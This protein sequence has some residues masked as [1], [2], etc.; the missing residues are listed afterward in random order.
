MALN[1]AKDPNTVNPMTFTI[2]SPPQLFC[3]SL[4]YFRFFP[5]LMISR[6]LLYINSLLNL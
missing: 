6:C 3:Q 5:K 4:L 2:F 1:C